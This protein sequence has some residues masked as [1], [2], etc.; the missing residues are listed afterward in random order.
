MSTPRQRAATPKQQKATGKW[1]F[2]V[3]LPPGPD[4]KRRQARRSGFASSRD[5]QA[6]LDL[7]RTDVREGTYVPDVNVSVQDYLVEEW[8]PAVRSSL[9]PSTWTSYDRAMRLRVIPKLG[10]LKLRD[11]SPSHLNRLYAELLA[12][13]RCDGQD[14]GLSPRSVRYTHTI[15]GRAMRDAV[16]WQRL[17][18]SPATAAEPPRAKDARAPEMVTWT[19]QELNTFLDAEKQTRYWIG[20]RLLATTGMRR[21]EALGVRWGDIDFDEGILAIRQTLTVDDGQ[22]RLVNRTKTGRS[23]VIHLDTA[24]VAALRSARK[25][26]LEE[27]ILFGAGYQDND[28]VLCRADG[29]PYHPERFSQEFKRRVTRH[30]LRRIR[31]HD[32]RHTWA[33]LALAAGVHPKVVQEQLGHASITITMDVYSHVVPSMKSEAAEKVAGLILGSGT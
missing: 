25:A 8:L 1:G 13:G 18:V 10:G 19:A 22:L 32:L 33:T 9:E 27:R 17:K 24:T 4:G 7:L 20:W 15:L 16:R 30:K 3:D 26:Q 21:G 14:G 5:A 2:V 12:N 29:R 31:L 28:L 11:L 6:A 23:R